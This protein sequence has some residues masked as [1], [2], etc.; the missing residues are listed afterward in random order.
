[1]KNQ[2]NNILEQGGPQ[3]TYISCEEPCPFLCVEHATSWSH[4]ESPISFTMRNS[5]FL[6]YF[7][8]PS[9]DRPYPIPIS[10]PFASLEH[11][12]L[13]EHFFFAPH[14]QNPC[15]MYIQSTTRPWYQLETLK[16]TV[17]QITDKK[18]AKPK[19]TLSKND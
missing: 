3:L 11:P 8:Y 16:A 6:A 7:L 10:Q 19:L 1:M 9:Q 2:P 14:L 17:G 18:T 15:I 4:L 12:Y 5:N 13:L